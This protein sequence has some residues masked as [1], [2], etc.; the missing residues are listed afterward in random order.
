MFTPEEMN[1]RWAETNQAHVAKR[2]KLLSIKDLEDLPPPTWLID[3][4]IEDNVLG[5]LYGASGDGKSFVALD[6]AL[7]IAT[8]QKWLNRAVNGGQVIYVVA[9][10]G[11]SFKKR[12]DAWVLENRMPAPTNMFV[13][14]DA[15]QFADPTHV[16]V[17]MSQIDEAVVAP[18]LIIID[19]LARCFL[20]GDENSSKEM[21]LFIAACAEVQQRS[22]ATVLAVHHT[23][24]QRGNRP[25]A[26]RGSNALR[27]A[28]DVMIRV[29]KKDGIITVDVD[30]QKDDEEAKNIR[31]R[32]KTVV[33]GNDPT[34]Q[35]A[36]T[37]CVLIPAGGAPPVP[38]RLG[39]APLK[40]LRALV[41]LPDA[42]AHS[43]DWREAVPPDGDERIPTRTFQNHR[44]DLIDG[45][46][47]VSVK[48]RDNWYQ[49]TQEGIAIAK[50]TPI[51]RHQQLPSVSAASATPPIGVAGGTGEGES[52]SVPREDSGPAASETLGTEGEGVDAAG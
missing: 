22:G 14:L 42:V 16:D 7:C 20:G 5:V 21:G 17:L 51:T 23:A 19:T 25:T 41:S 8:N 18:R 49:A 30:K 15:V 4:I 37:S 3:G 11:R 9:E 12:I 50:P 31:L 29:S 46:F 43:T 48:G 26:E 45:G 13:I 34:T 36:V 33:V 24:K 10:G 52:A 44:A 47:V 40:T 28:A 2:F 32:M 6:W 35:K 38:P 1:K 39:S 27:G